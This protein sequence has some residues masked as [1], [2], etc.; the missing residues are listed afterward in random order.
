[1]REISKRIIPVG[2]FSPSCNPPLS[3]LRLEEG[4]L[5]VWHIGVLDF[6]VFVDIVKVRL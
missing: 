2:I 5:R 6:V 4:R 3:Q 1:M